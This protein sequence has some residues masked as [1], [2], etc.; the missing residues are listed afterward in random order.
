MLIV[1]GEFVY[2][3]DEE[4]HTLHMDQLLSFKALF[5]ENES[6]AEI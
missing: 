3:D 1:H 6:E 4:A 5:M 2:H